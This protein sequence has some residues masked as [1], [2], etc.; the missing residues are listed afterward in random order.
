MGEAARG[1]YDKAVARLGNTR[2]RCRETEER[3]V[4]EEYR[5]T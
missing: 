2:G 4:G 3:V 5:I 1:H